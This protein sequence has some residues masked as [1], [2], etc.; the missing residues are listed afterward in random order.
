[1][2]GGLDDAARGE[3]VRRDGE[4]DDL[5]SEGERTGSDAT[6][7]SLARRALER[8]AAEPKASLELAAAALV[9]ALACH[10]AAARW[11]AHRARGLALKELG[12]IPEAEA[13]LRRARRIALSAGLDRC[14]ANAAMSLSVVLLAAGNSAGALRFCRL[15]A[16]HLAGLD[17]ARLAAQRG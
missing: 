12:Q 4:R 14:A 3:P 1:A 6:P 9:S 13:E 5:T 2:P 11:V 8:A 7:L 16:P 10:D 15:A 17:A